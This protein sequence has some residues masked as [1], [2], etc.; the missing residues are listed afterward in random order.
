MSFISVGVSSDK[1][2]TPLLRKHVRCV[3]PYFMFSTIVKQI[4]VLTSLDL[5]SIHGIKLPLS[6]SGMSLIASR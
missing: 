6:G 5:R 3:G 1:S 4:D 2:L